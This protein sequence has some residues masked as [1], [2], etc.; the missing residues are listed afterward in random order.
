LTRCLPTVSRRA[1]LVPLMAAFFKVASIVF[2]G[3]HVFRWLSTFRRPAYDIECLQVSV[4]SSFFTAFPLPAPRRFAI[5]FGPNVLLAA[6]L[7]PESLMIPAFR[8]VGRSPVCSPDARA[9]RTSIS[10]LAARPR[11]FP[12]AD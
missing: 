12:Q 4:R 1:S 11:A 10:P 2:Q 7:F 9:A 3:G 5:F 6:R 8:P